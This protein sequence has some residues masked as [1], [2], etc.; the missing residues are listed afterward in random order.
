MASVLYTIG[1]ERRSLGELLNL[2]SYAGV[3]RLVDV[4]ELP[5]S[6]RRGFSKSSLAASLADVGVQYEHVKPLGNPRENRNRYRAGDIRGGARV[7]HG[8]LHNDS[9]PALL[10]LAAS[11]GDEPICLLCFERDHAAC[12]RDIIVESLRELRPDLA[13]EHL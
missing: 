8:H 2:L 5:L 12:H 10:Q 11:L 1:Y 7:F 9:Y 4:R 6:R 13:V 3:R